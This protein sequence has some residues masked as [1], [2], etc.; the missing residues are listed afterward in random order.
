MKSSS[1]A[2]PITNPVGHHRL[3]QCS[4]GLVLAMMYAAGLVFTFFAIPSQAA[5]TD[6]ETLSTQW[7]STLGG[8]ATTVALHELGHFVVAGIEDAEPYFDDLTVKYHNLD[9]TDRQNL[10]LSSAGFQAQ[11]LVSEYAFHRLKDNKLTPGQTAWN[12]GLVLGHLG[13]TAAYL[14]F[15]R[16]HE[17]GDVEGIA[18]ATGLSNG[19]VLALITL[20]ALLDTWR[21]FGDKTPRWASWVSP[22]YKALGIS[23]VWAF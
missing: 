15:L 2:D 6:I 19:E 18:T 3:V 21:L 10:R 22:G 9:G 8:A 13:I 12:A 16:D 7:K 11:W 1:P 4:R 5:E 23:A 14:T 20:P 17:D